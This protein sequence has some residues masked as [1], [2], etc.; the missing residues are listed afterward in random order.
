MRG[1]SI[2]AREVMQP[3]G[4]IGLGEDTLDNSGVDI[5]ICLRAIS[6]GENQPTLIHC[7]QGKDRTG[8]MIALSLLLLR[9]PVDAITYDY[10][11]SVPGLVEERESRLMEIASIGLGEE[12][13]GCPENW[14]EEMVKHLDEKYGGIDR[15]CRSIGFSAGEEKELVDGLSV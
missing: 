2:M 3:R 12:F 15:Y 7:T 14:V 13:A 6:T 9:V 11:L 1:I 5:A 10:L 4:L 8:L